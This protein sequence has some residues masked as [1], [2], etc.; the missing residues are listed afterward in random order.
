MAIGKASDFKIYNDEFFGGMTEV[1]MQQA[2]AFNAASLNAIRLVP[3][4]HKG[5]Y[6]KE[7]FLKAISSLISRRDTTSVSAATDLAMTQD[8]MIAVKL[9]RKIGPVAQTLDAWRKIAVDPQTMSFLLGQQ[10]A[11]AV[12]V[13]YINT[14]LSGVATALGGVSSWGV[15]KS[16]ASPATSTHTYL[17]DALAKMGDNAGQVV[18]W[19]MHSKPYYDLVKQAIAD[20]VF[21]VAGVTIMRGTVA[22]FNRPTLVIDSSSLIVSGSPDTY[23]TLGLVEDACEVAESEQREIVSDLVTGLENL[24]MRIQG[25]YAFNLKVKGFKW[26]VT[27][28]GANPAAATVATASNWDKVV[29]DNKQLAGVHLITQ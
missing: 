22:T 23:I 10:T 6:E 15:D 17:V 27:N 12:M 8:E 13:D 9:N 24:V 4:R 25:E 14:A 3:D 1:L 11:K 7:S 5:D 20:K 26:D 29:S 2:D 16:A 21:E 28:G 19:V 18:C